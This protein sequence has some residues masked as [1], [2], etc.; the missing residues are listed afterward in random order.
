MLGPQEAGEPAGGLVAYPP[1]EWRRLVLRPPFWLWR[2]GLAPLMRGRFCVLTTLGRESRRPSRV[3]L[4]YTAFGGRAY[5]LAGWQ[6]RSHLF[7]SL[8]TEPRVTLESGLG[9][10]RGRAVRVVDPDLLR[11]LHPE[12]RKTPHWRR[13]TA[14]WGVDGGDVEDVARNAERLWVFRIDPTGGDTPK[15]RGRGRPGGGGR[16]RGD[17]RKPN[18]GRGGPSWIR[19]RDHPVMSRLL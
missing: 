17:A 13:Y 15:R 8:L 16:R 7:R 19:T 4:E 12:L 9:V 1:G 5:V 14:A 2:I 10:E 18:A 6:P 11:A 3:L